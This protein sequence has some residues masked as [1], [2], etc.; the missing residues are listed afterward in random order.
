MNED[1]YKCV[2]LSEELISAESVYVLSLLPKLTSGN[3]TWRIS[4][5]RGKAAVIAAIFYLIMS[6]RKIIPINTVRKILNATTVKFYTEWGRW[7]ISADG[8][9]N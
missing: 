2:E 8:L 3:H 7:H 6:N 4:Q 5:N 1:M 9:G